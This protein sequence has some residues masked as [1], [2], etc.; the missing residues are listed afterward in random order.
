MLKGMRAFVYFLYLLYKNRVP[1]TIDP[2]NFDC[3]YV[4]NKTVVQ[5]NNITLLSAI[6]LPNQKVICN[7]IGT[8]TEANALRDTDRFYLHAEIDIDFNSL[9]IGDFSLDMI[10]IIENGLSFE[11]G[12]SCIYKNLRF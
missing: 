12:I 4:V 1:I 9:S 6:D 3:D 8:S 11:N 5:D 2:I 7:I 10:G